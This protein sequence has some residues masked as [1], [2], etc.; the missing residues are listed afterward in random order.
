VVWFGCQQG[1]R[2]ALRCGVPCL[3]EVVTGLE[4]PGRRPF[5]AC[6]TLAVEPRLPGLD[7]VPGLVPVPGLAKPVS[8]LPLLVMGLTA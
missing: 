3:P 1:T 8:G 2:E 7:P 4:V 5:I 6:S